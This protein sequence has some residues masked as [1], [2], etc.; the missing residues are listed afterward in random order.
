MFF[1][2]Q[3]E[4][5]ELDKLMPD[6][7]YILKYKNERYRVYVKDNY[8]NEGDDSDS[9]QSYTSSNNHEYTKN[10]DIIFVDQDTKRKFTFK[11][12]DDVEI[13]KSPN[14]I[15]KF[16]LVPSE[17]VCLAGEHRNDLKLRDY[18]C[19]PQATEYLRQLLPPFELKANANIKFSSTDIAGKKTISIRNLQG[20]S[21]SPLFSAFCQK[22]A[23]NKK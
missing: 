12:N 6:T 5:V 10:A 4:K 7:M 9:D 14:E 19:T 16:P 15:K 11:S 20:K 3:L 17:V 13:Y 1:Q 2:N 23:A 21:L 22:L 18:I 8:M